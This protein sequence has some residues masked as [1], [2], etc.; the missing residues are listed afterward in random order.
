[1]QAQPARYN[2]FYV[3]K[4]GGKIGRSVFSYSQVIKEKKYGFLKGI[5]QRWRMTYEVG[6]A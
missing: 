3:L 5:E 1:M 4:Q 2:N 6:T